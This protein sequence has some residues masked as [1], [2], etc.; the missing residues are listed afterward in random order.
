[1]LGLIVIQWLASALSMMVILFLN[2][3][4]YASENYHCQI[5]FSNVRGMLLASLTLSFGPTIT[6]VVIYTYI[7]H[8]LKTT[9]TSTILQNRIRS[10]RR[11]IIVLRRILLLIG[12]V[13]LLSLPILVIWLIYLCTGYLNP[14]SYHFEWLFFAISS[15]TLSIAS[16]VLSPHLSRL[17]ITR[18]RR[19]RQIQPAVLNNS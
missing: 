8:H 14:L 3:F 18:W 5:L 9:G 7:M 13:V 12:A 17:I 2:G 15:A 16:A 6:S 11:D 4:E 10:N 1:M 19:R